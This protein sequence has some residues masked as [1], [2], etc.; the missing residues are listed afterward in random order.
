MVMVCFPDHRSQQE[1]GTIA[2]SSIALGGRL[3]FSI[4]LNLDGQLSYPERLSVS[5]LS[6]FTAICRLLEKF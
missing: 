2:D 1:A 6:A 4:N 5:Y 3:F